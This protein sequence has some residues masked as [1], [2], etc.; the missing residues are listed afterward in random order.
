MCPRLE[1]HHH[2]LV[3]DQRVVEIDLEAH[4]E[5][6]LGQQRRGGAAGIATLDRLQHL[7]RA[8]RR[9]PAAIGAGLLDQFDKRRRTAIH[10]R[11]FRPVELDDR[12]VDAAAA[13]AAIRCSTVLTSIPSPFD[14]T[15][16][17]GR[18]RCCSRSRA[19][20]APASILRNTMPGVRAPPAATSS[21]RAVRNEG[22][23][24]G[25]VAALASVRCR[26]IPLVPH[27][28]PLV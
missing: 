13:S 20:S 23:C 24:R 14:S 15:V 17:S 25:M 8:P 12:V 3:A 21:R 10:R 11:H 27:H 4:R 2:V 22:R 16:H 18:R 9:R 5:A 28:N 26:M 7:D 19:I 1:R 6:V